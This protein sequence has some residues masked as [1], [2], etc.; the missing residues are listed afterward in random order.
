MLFA[1]CSTIGCVDIRN[2]IFEFRNPKFGI[3]Y[4]GTGGLLRQGQGVT[5]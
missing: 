5:R 2:P 1:R 3:F 4:A